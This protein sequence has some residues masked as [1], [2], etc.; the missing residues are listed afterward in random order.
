MDIRNIPAQTT[1]HLV[2]L[3]IAVVCELAQRIGVPVTI[4]A[5]IGEEDPEVA[6]GTPPEADMPAASAPGTP[7]Y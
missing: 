5:Q 2:A 6:E 3:L 7:W 4:A 1:H